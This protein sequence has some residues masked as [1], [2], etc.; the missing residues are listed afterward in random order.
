MAVITLASASGSPGVT[1]TCLGLALCWPRPVLL[2]EADPTG[3]SSLL[4]GYFRGTREYRAGV[5]ELALTGTDLTDTLA[6]VA[7]PINDTP[8]S[9]VAG[10]RSHTQAA[11][12][13]DLWEP[14]SVVLGDLE[15]TGQDVIID[16]GRLGLTG[17]P[18]PLLD[19]A[20]L[21]LIAT[22]TSLPALSATRSWGDAVAR[23][24][25]HWREPQLLLVGEGDPYR[26]REVTAAVKLPVLA[27]LADDPES[28][29]VLHRGA[30][31]SPKFDSAPLVRS[32]NAA[33]AAVHAVVRAQRLDLVEGA[34][35]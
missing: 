4:A 5:V 22:R 15:A 23:S 1:T 32:L 28:A 14:L 25:V 3:G 24:L 10:T 6:E 13:R 34:A 8:V 30:P 26:A 17:S 12:L 2:V 16:A 31:P 20:D 33:V 18:T 19:N 35:R 27:T 29:A 9:Y 21:V 11:A 7:E